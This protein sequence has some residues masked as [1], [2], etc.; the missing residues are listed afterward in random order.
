MKIMADE[1]FIYTRKSMS[2]VVDNNTNNI[3]IVHLRFQIQ[4]P[5]QAFNTNCS[6]PGAMCTGRT[7]N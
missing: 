1:I 2:G 4:P 5:P 3:I 7:L 6:L